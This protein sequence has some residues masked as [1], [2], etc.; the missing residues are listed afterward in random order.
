MAMLLLGIIAGALLGFTIHSEIYRVNLKKL[1]ILVKKEL[2]TAYN[3]GVKTGIIQPTLDRLQE[4]SKEQI[5]CI[6]SI[7]RPSASAAHSRYKN[8]VVSQ[9]KQLEEEK[10]KLLRGILARGFD[11]LLS[12]IMTDGQ[13]KSMKVSE[14]VSM[15][16]S[17]SISNETSQSTTDPNSSCSAKTL[18]LVKSTKEN[19]DDGKPNPSDPKIH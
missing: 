16:E 18:R 15:L 9:I 13:T 10:E 17:E 3:T 1:T 2:E 14:I 5:D 4:I 12:I 11:P 19:Q 6:N 7:D 8:T